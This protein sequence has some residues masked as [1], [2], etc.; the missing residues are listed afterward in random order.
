MA[1]GSPRSS[2]WRVSSPSSTEEHYEWLLERNRLLFRSVVYR[3]VMAFL[4]PEMLAR[5]A[6]ARWSNFH[7]GTEFRFEHTAAHEGIAE[8][9][10]PPN[11]FDATLVQLFGA[12]FVA[13]LERANASSVTM[14]VDEVTPTAGRYRVEWR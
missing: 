10:F 14:T 7:Q 8:L 11:L 1:S 3:A 13:A 2:C 4:A 5:K 6:S 12:V 9:T